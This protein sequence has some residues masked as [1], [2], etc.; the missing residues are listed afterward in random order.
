M[1]RRERRMLERQGKLTKQEP[2]FH[3]K[4]SQLGQYAVH[5]PGEKAMRHEIDQQLLE[6]DKQFTLDVDTMVLWTLHTY[7]G[8]GPKR[9]KEFYINMFR[10]HLCMREYYEMDDLY[11]ERAK[12]KERGIDVE[13][14]YNALFD[15]EGNFKNPK[16]VDL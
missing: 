9:A 15:D 5:G 11:P 4:P 16:E 1:N 12:L 8:F 13:A 3:V 6:L 10:E 7:Y 2:T 14:W